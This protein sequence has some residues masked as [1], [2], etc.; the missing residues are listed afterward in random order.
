MRGGDKFPQLWVLNRPKFIFAYHFVISHWKCDCELQKFLYLLL[1]RPHW[2]IQS[3]WKSYFLLDHSLLGHVLLLLSTFRIR[4]LLIFAIDHHHHHHQLLCLHSN[5]L[6]HRAIISGSIIWKAFNSSP[7]FNSQ[8]ELWATQKRSPRG[9]L[10]C[11]SL[12]GNTIWRN[13]IWIRWMGNVLFITNNLLFFLPF[14]AVS[15]SATHEIIW[16][17]WWKGDW[18]IECSSSQ[19]WLVRISFSYTTP[20]TFSLGSSLWFHFH[21]NP[22]HLPPL[23][24]PTAA[25]TYSTDQ[26]KHGQT[27]LAGVAMN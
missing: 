17:I 26:T 2:L 16:R 3:K 11:K 25:P 22:I 15:P 6:H 24:P 27:L 4:P 18:S 5:R 7:D 1:F 13:L 9:C 20:K 12:S 23:N 21:L 10:G 19:G 8:K 14:L